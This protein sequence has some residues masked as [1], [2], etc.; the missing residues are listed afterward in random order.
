MKNSFIFLTIMVLIFSSS[1][2]FSQPEKMKDK[3]VREKM[4][5][6]EKIKLM[7]E[8]DLNE[9]TAI[10]FFARRNE[11]QDRV[12]AIEDELDASVRNLEALIKNKTSKENEIKTEISNFTRLQRRKAEEIDSF[13]NSLND[14][15]TTEQIATLIVFEKKFRDEIRTLI[16]KGRNKFK[17]DD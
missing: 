14:I 10:R 17:N 15:L 7:E 4:N 2:L 12:R 13:I 16:V 8:M 11:H 6:L 9:E 3:K 5:K 1:F